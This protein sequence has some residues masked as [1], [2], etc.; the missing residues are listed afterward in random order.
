MRT[1]LEYLDSDIYQVTARYVEI[2]GQPYVMELLRKMDEEFLV[3]LENRD[4]LMEKLSGYNEK[5]YQDALTGVYN[6]RYY[7]DRIKKMT[8]S[9]GVAMIDMDDF[10]IYND[11]YGHNAGDLA[12]ITTVEAIRR[13]IRKNT[14][15]TEK[16]FANEEGEDGTALEALKVK[17]QI[18]IVDDSEMN[19]AIL[20]N[21]LE[22]DFEIME[23]SDGKELSPHCRSIARTCRP[24]CWTS[25]CRRWTVFRCWRR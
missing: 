13:C 4:R 19:R 14:V 8:A 21:M 3:D 24:C 15:V 18:L 5:L 6:R 12:L 7:E 9:V 22:Q 1:K 10:K 23:V 20:A 11:T 17:Q 25:L 2:D 16:D